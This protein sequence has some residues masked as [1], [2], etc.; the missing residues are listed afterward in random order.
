MH[1]ASLNIVAD[2]DRTWSSFLHDGA[3]DCGHEEVATHRRRR[4]V[5]TNCHTPLTRLVC[6]FYPR[7][8]ASE[9]SCEWTY[10][11]RSYRTY[12]PAPVI[13]RDVNLVTTYGDT[14]SVVWLDGFVAEENLA[15]RLSLA[16]CQVNFR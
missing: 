4:E 12:R 15:T 1:G 14:S 2:F 3:S 9:S 5:W 13:H 16:G 7:Q 6:G 11:T 8:E 10:G